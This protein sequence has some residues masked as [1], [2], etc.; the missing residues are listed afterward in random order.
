M[1][2]RKTQLDSTGCGL[3][4]VAM[5]GDIG[6]AQA[7]SL[8]RQLGIVPKA[9]GEASGGATRGR[10]K[11]YYTSANELARMLRLLGAR[12]GRE[13]MLERADALDSDGIL[14]I[15]PNPRDGSW[16]WVVYI[17][18][19]DGGYVLDPNPRVR[20]E[21]RNDLRRMRCRSFLPVHSRTD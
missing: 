10:R 20:S 13:R 11:A 15:N 12:P 2:R 1:I 17:H 14:G 7:R 19:D 16:H 18:D 8:A 3:A 9:P 6:Y 21:R 5:L 4:C